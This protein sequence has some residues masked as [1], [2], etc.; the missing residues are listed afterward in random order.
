MGETPNPWSGLRSES[1][2]GALELQPK[3]IEGLVNEAIEVRIRV[4]SVKAELAKVD[5]L[6][7]FAA[8]VPSAAA[9]ADRF[10]AKGRDLKSILEDHTKILDD[11]GDT[12]LAA[13]KAYGDSDTGG[14]ADFAALRGRINADKGKT[15]SLG[16][17]PQAFGRCMDITVLKKDGGGVPDS[18]LMPKGLKFDPMIVNAEDPTQFTYAQYQT[19]IAS[20]ASPDMSVTVAQAAT[21]WTWLAGRLKEKFDELSN[22]MIATESSWRSPGNAGGADRAR[23]AIT[24]YGTGNKDL[25]DGMKALGTALQYV[26]DWVYGTRT[27]LQAVSATEVPLMVPESVRAWETRKELT[28]QQ[29]YANAMK[30]TYVL[31]VDHTADVIALLPDPIPPTTG[32][33]PTGNGTGTGAGTG[34]GGGSGSG[35]GAGA[36]GLSSGFQNGMS[37]LTSAAQTAAQQAASDAAKAAARTAAEQA[38]KAAEDAAKQAQSAASSGLEQAAS[39]LTSGM[40]QASSAAQSALDQASAAAAEQ[41]AL[42][43][44]PGLAGLNSALEEQAKKMTSAAKSGG[45]G[46][47]AGGGAGGGLPGQNLQNASSLFPRAAV[48]ATGLEGMA[49]R[50]GIAG[51]AGSPM[52][53]MPMAPMGGAGAGAGGQQKEHKRADYLDSVEHLEEAI[54]AAPIVARPV[55]EQ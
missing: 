48:T 50:A 22:A 31:G 45:G 47:G 38:T 27:S 55:I 21:D 9:L 39:A 3:V 42:S 13:G 53:G 41:S 14:K 6:K 15:E 51:G 54:G 2:S 44:V 35:S 36:S 46:G 18:L 40:E 30:S 52:G 23:Q 12:F 7:A 49:S 43:S 1:L 32:Q 34:S 37:A 17:R 10:S 8:V 29:G 11:M 5:N 20:M 28:H 25:V 16:Q 4:N 33:Q 26:S 19:I 24:A